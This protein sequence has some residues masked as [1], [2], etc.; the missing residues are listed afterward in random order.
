MQDPGS[1]SAMPNSERS[2]PLPKGKRERR[3]ARKRRRSEAVLD[4]PEDAEY[5]DPR[6]MRINKHEPPSLSSE[7]QISEA[8]EGEEDEDE[9]EEM[10]GSSA[11]EDEDE[12]EDE[13]AEEDEEAGS[14]S[15]SSADAARDMLDFRRVISTSAIHSRNLDGVTSSASPKSEDADTDNDAAAHE[16]SS[17]L[18]EESQ[19]EIRLPHTSKHGERQGRRGALTRRGLGSGRGRNLQTEASPPLT[20][21]SPGRPFKGKTRDEKGMFRAKPSPGPKAAA[22]AAAKN[23][24]DRGFKSH[25]AQRKPGRAA[26]DGSKRKARGRGRQVIVVDDSEAEAAETAAAEEVQGARSAEDGKGAETAQQ[27]VAGVATRQTAR[28]TAGIGPGPPRRDGGSSLGRDG[29][30]SLESPSFGS[31]SVRG[32][33]RWPAKGPT[34]TPITART[35][36][37]ATATPATESAVADEDDSPEQQPLDGRRRRRHRAGPRLSLVDRVGN[38]AL[39]FDGAAETEGDDAE[40][41]DGER[42]GEGERVERA[43]R[44]D[45][46][47]EQDG[48]EEVESES[49]EGDEVEE[50]GDEEAESEAESEEAEDEE[51]Q[52][53]AEAEEAESSPA[54]E[55]EEGEEVEGEEAESESEIDPNETPQKRGWRTR[56]KNMAR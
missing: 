28:K 32:K 35:A 29:G 18:A 40:D 3:N 56:H 31:S 15:D 13:E 19:E 14:D 17:S 52:S 11:E 2:G 12:D 39:A 27:A 22:A 41:R 7:E 25:K 53:D 8:E 36:T 20:A 48:E 45:K 16:S 10:T 5:V 49:E 26:K 9:D 43:E 1:S 37:E 34:A 38:R 55:Q 51:A 54:Q 6:G 30:S 24:G 47:G 33:G 50:A 44:A 42:R 21:L 4:D 23:G 46:S